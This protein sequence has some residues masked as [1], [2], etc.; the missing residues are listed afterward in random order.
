MLSLQGKRLR[1]VCVFLAASAGSGI[2]AG[3]REL[4]LAV[5]VIH[6]A[7]LLHDDIIDSAPIRRGSPTAW[8]RFGVKSATF[9]GDHLLIDGL[10]RVAGA[11]IGGAFEDLLQ[12][13]ELMILGETL[14]LEQ[15]GSIHPC[16]ESWRRIAGGKT[17]ALFDWC[18]ST[19]GKAGGLGQPACDALGR[20]GYELG[21]A[22]QALDDLLDVCGDVEAT[23]KELLRDLED[24]KMSLPLIFACD[25]EP[26][27]KSDLAGMWRFESQEERY[28]IAA[29][30]QH[31]RVI[32]R[33]LTT[34]EQHLDHAR[35]AV[36]QCFDTSERER[37]FGLLDLIETTAGVPRKFAERK[38][39]APR[40]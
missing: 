10:S 33:C 27:V 39:I 31:P 38:P 34:I 24:G 40:A 37:L 25:Q 5:E 15:R 6:A 8:T 28:R 12:T 23:G 19:G 26:A 13:I 32:A 36:T 3:A 1:P 35:T 18:L 21:L 29:A 17:A 7:T 2:D 9:A 16:L 11:G 22:F 4:A 14:Q 20:F 30:L